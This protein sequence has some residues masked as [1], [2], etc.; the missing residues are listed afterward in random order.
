VLN[1]GHRW[2]GL[3]YRDDGA[4]VAEEPLAVDWE[5][6]REWAR[7]SAVRAGAGSEAFL[8]AAETL[9]PLWHAELGEP[10]LGGVRV[11]LELGDGGRSAS[12]IASAYFAESLRAATARL[13][14]RGTLAEGETCRY[15][16][17]AYPAAAAEE[18][19]AAPFALAE[20]A[21]SLAL[22][23]AELAAR[24][25]ASLPA[26]PEADGDVPVFL[27]AET[28]A[29]ADEL[30][31]DAGARET[32][33]VLL[34]NLARDAASD[35]VFVEVTAQIPARAARGELTRLTFDPATWTDV[36][37]AL[38]LRRRGEIMLGWWH[39]HPVREWCKACAPERRAGCRL[40]SGFFSAHDRAL[41]RTVFP[42]AYSLG[43]VVN[44]VDGE[45]PTHSLFGW[46]GGVIAERG[47][48][49]LAAAPI[50]EGRFDDVVFA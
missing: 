16:V 34:G 18:A 27:P 14:E 11:E 17:A 9:V 41:H 15:L 50:N 28:L 29:E 23:P 13:V 32:G 12:E 20:R 6:A 36:R 22:V 38:E 39:S 31:L 48:R 30:A 8:P 3:F 24:E 1:D 37:A 25:R 43:L 33:G 47:F 49:R 5:P 10:Y 44:V 35:A 26:T 4:T 45:R 19:K 46:R 2:V 7:W 42:R 21:P 40:A